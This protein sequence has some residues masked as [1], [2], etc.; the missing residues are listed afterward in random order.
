MRIS[1]SRNIRSLTG[2]FAVC[3]CLGMVA[4]IILGA[5]DSLA[6]SAA[7][8]LPEIRDFDADALT[9]EDGGSVIYTF[10]V[11]NATSVQ[12]KE[13]SEI[14]KL[15][16]APS[17]TKLKGKVEGRTTYQ[18]RVGGSNSFDAV[19]TAGN[20]AGKRMKKVTIKYASVLQEEPADAATGKPGDEQDGQAEKP[21]WLEQTDSTLNTASG[22]ARM[23]A[24]PNFFK[25]PE[26][27]K[28]CLKQGDAEGRGFTQRC[29]E[30]PCYYSPDDQ[31]KWF[32]YSQQETVWCCDEGVV[33]ETT[34]EVCIRRGGTYY[35]TEAEAMKRCQQAATGWYCYQGTLFQGSREQAAQVG[36]PWY[37]SQAEAARYC[38]PEGW[39]CK[40]GKVGQTTQSQC[41]QL[42]GG[43]FSS[44]AEAM[45]A[46][47]QAQL[48]WYCYQGTVYQGTQSQ[49]A[50]MGVAWYGTQA[51]ALKACQQQ[52]TCWCCSGGKVFQTTA[53]SCAR[54]QG[55]CYSTQGA[56]TEACQQQS[57]CW[58][59][60][61]GKVF[62]TTAASCARYQGT[63]YST[64]AAATKACSTYT[65]PRTY[66]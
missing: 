44:Q 45:K 22:V 15:I 26:D 32:C 36:A 43:W 66:K 11:W 48:G 21:R 19:L 3:L 51:E 65:Q 39:C 18:I 50:Q 53:A 58:C 64:Q 5:A 59:C 55:T 33:T 41:N 63:C 40:D 24:E 4:V 42:G 60:S 8:S 35:A 6:A 38:N 37:S 14:L 49:A 2:L 12:I 27:C 29:S 62:Q 34:K 9:V 56:A 17:S 47:Q 20:T 28:H 16:T 54:Y 30:E 7:G 57:T 1:K 31:Q 13:A 61:G 10:E 52:S 25:C 46:C 23:G